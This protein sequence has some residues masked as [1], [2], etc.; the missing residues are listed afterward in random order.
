MNMESPTNAK[1][2][3]FLAATALCPVMG[4]VVA[5]P[6][7][8]GQV[9]HIQEPKTKG[10]YWLYLPEDYGKPA[11]GAGQQ[12]GR[13]LVVTYHGMKPFDAAK[14]QIREWQQEA[15]RYGFIVV[16]P[17]CT[18]PDLLQ[19][20][21][22]RHVH[23][24]VKRDEELSIAMLEDV[25]KRADVDP[26]KILST[27]WSFGGYLAH[28]MANRYPDWFSCVAP[29]QSNFSAEILDVAQIPK[30][31]QTKIGIFYT[32]NDFAICRRESQEAA[33]WYAKHGFD[34]TFA[35]F[36]DLG[37]ERRPSVA[38]AF[39]AKTCDVSAKTPPV[40]L[41]RMQVRQ[42]PLPEPA[43]VTKSMSP[44]P[45]E[46]DA[47]STSVSAYV[48]GGMNRPQ[49]PALLNGQVGNNAKAGA[50]AG[51]D[52]GG[53]PLSIRVNSTVGIAPHFVRY[54]VLAPEAERRG[55]FFLWTDNGEP[56]SN[57]VNGQTYLATKGEHVLEVCM[58]TADGRQ[59]RAQK[60][61]TVLEPVEN[62]PPATDLK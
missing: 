34:V 29:R 33:K 11:P 54:S 8:N 30:Y 32:Q 37:H 62:T 12:K 36:K 31:R 26:T 49:R 51:E 60:T 15:D 58:T 47:A 46:P 7:G 19:E 5:Q 18:S 48:A 45:S 35:V 41:A 39:F 61:I 44:T 14:S 27:S 42:L 50:P 56:I 21:P 9:L 57:G 3:Y 22:L 40:E 24:G 52:G 10:W 13:P 16:A 2:V 59:F 43:K 23:S 25:T 4:C 17:E 55:A 1:W 38:A 53:G 6:P 28:Y 20:F